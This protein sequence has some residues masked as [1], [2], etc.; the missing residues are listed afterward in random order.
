MQPLN[1]PAGSPGWVVKLDRKSGK[2]LG[3]VWVRVYRI[4]AEVMGKIDADEF[5]ARI[6]PDYTSVR[7][8]CSVTSIVTA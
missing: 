7:A 6:D 5:R 2:I 3:Y 8:I 1:E 4:P